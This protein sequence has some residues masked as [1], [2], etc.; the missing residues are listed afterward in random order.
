MRP[1]AGAIGLGFILL[2]NNVRP[3]RAHVTNASLECE[4]IVCMDWPA[5]SPDLN[6]IEHAWDILQCVI[7]ARPVRPRTSQ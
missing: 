3:H 1:N 2:D 7:S 6:S 4:A 5:R